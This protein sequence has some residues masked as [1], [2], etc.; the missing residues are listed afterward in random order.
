[1][2]AMR[3]LLLIESVIKSLSILRQDTIQYEMHND[4]YSVDS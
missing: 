4:D 2:E 3:G 1:M